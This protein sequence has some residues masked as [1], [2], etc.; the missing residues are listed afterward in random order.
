VTDGI[1]KAETVN[2]DELGREVFEFTL[3][4]ERFSPLWVRFT[5][6]N[7]K[8]FLFGT[9]HKI[10]AKHLPRHVAKSNYHLNRRTMEKDLLELAFRAC[11][12]T[13]T[14]TYI[15]LQPRRN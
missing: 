13:Q 3:C 6:P 8:R 9:H 7:L 11:L 5:L 10:E 15:N 1:L 14:I 4:R 2:G 12:A